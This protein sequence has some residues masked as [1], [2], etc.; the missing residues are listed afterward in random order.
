[1]SHTPISTRCIF[2]AGL[3]FTVM[4]IVPLFSPEPIPLSQALVPTPRTLMLPEADAFGNAKCRCLVKNISHKPVKINF[5]SAACGCTLPDFEKSVL[6]PGESR[7]MN[8]QVHGSRGTFDKQV[9]IDYE[10][11]TEPQIQASVIISIQRP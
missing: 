7:P 8:I 1:M 2:T 5:V 4:A 3:L 11:E 9:A 6:A 10:F